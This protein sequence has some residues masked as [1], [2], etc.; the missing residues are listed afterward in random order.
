MRAAVISLSCLVIGATNT[1][2]QPRADNRDSAALRYELGQ[3]LK[4]FE[5]AWEKQPHEEARKRALPFVEKIT[6]QFF[7]FQFGEAGRSLDRASYALLTANE[8]SLTRQWVWSLFAVPETRVVD[9]A[10]KELT[11]TIQSFYPI[12]G[13]LPKGCEVQLWFNDQQ[14]TKSTPKKL[15]HTLAVPL[16]PLGEFQQLDRKLYFLVEAGSEMRYT[17]IGISQI[18]KLN[19]RLAAL[20][21]AADDRAAP[22]TIEKATL[23]SRVALLTDL[24]AGISPETDLPAG[25]LL[26]NAETMLNGQPFFGIDKTGQFWLSVPIE[27]QKATPVRIF[28]PHGLDAK[29]PVPV[30][31]A[32]HGAG[33][34]ENLFF[35]G[36][37]AGQIVKECR[38]RGWLLVAPRSGALFG[39]APPVP[40][41]L[42]QLAQRYPI[43]RQRVFV[44]GHSMGAMQTM[45]LVQKHPGQFAAVAALGGGGTIRDAKAFAQLPIFIGVGEKDTLALRGARALKT[46]LTHNGAEQLIYK[47]YPAIE[48]MVIVRQA[49]PDVFALF[50]QVNRSK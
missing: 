29:K 35:E 40:A 36:Y 21:K 44:V 2:A 17:T 20:K 39:A 42:D 32:L 10:T 5:M 14:V 18:N 13:E 43:N 4:R 23:R 45:E 9:G 22:E 48:H 27:G 31:V 37:G 33:G 11:V 30:V 41:L 3:R 47:E 12:R 34:S 19:D 7:S 8:P 28:V 6:Q 46:T 50:D 15:P 49:L 25:Q 26:A 24:A 16:P 1:A 38:E